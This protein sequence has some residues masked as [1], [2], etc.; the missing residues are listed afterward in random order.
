MSIEY[1]VDSLDSVE[2]SLRPAYEQGEGGKYRLNIEKYGELRTA[3]LHAKNKQL[4]DEK[5]KLNA[6]VRVNQSAEDRIKDLESE[7]RRYKLLTPLKDMALK[8]GAM[9][10]RIDVVMADLEKRVTLDE[11]GEIVVLDR[12]GDPTD[13]TPEQF[14]NTRYRDERPFFFEASKAGGGGAQNSNRAPAGGGKTIK[15][16][17]FEA[18][19]P[20]ER[21]TFVKGGGQVIDNY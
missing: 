14:L 21:M 15:R 8:A 5:K 1:L 10:D 13:L 2:E 7:V 11:A 4:L 9:A 12:N 18:L 20:Q 3:P 6:A 17:A 19:G 16:A